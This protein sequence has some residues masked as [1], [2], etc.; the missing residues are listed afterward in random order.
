MNFY[1]GIR[2][3]M[4][5]GIR[6]V[7]SFA[8]SKRDISTGPRGVMRFVYVGTAKDLISQKMN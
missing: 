4:V 5:R 8:Y 7:V 3:A 1:A 6:C 2:D